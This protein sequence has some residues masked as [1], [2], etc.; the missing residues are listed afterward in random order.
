MHTKILADNQKKEK[1]KT[2]KRTA[3]LF[4]SI[5]VMYN[6]RVAPKIGVANWQMKIMVPGTE[7]AW[8]AFDRRE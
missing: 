1:E 5:K 8:I 2:Y 7:P 6:K 4:K 3:N